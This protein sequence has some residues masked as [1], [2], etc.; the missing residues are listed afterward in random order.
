MQTLYLMRH[1]QTEYNVQHILQG[2]CDGSRHDQ[3]GQRRS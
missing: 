2:R 3:S 1:G